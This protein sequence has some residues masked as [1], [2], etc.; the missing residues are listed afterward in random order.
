MAKVKLKCEICLKYSDENV[1]YE[2][3]VENF[4]MLERVCLAC[5]FQVKKERD[6]LKKHYL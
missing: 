3:I 5:L 6:G 1:V 2:Y 4:L